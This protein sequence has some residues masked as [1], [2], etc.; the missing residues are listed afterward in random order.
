MRYHEYSIVFVLSSLKFGGTE[1]VAL[2]LA[3]EFKSRGFRVTFLLLSYEGEYLNEAVKFFN[4]FDLRCDRTWKLPLKLISY[5][6]RGKPDIL[7]SSFWKLNVCACI[8]R[9]F[10]QKVRLLLWEHSP[11]SRSKNSSTFLYAISASILYRFATN[12]IAV[13]SGVWNDIDSNTIGLRNKL[14]VI[15]NPIPDPTIFIDNN[16]VLKTKRRIVWVG[17][18]DYSKNPDLMLD[19]FMILSKS[20]GFTL[21]FVGDGPLRINLEKKVLDHDLAEVVRFHG[22]QSNPYPL[23]MQS[24]ILA[25]T[26]DC[27]G[28]PTVLI[29]ALYLGLRVVSTDSGDGIHDI[30]LD[31][32]Y[33][34][35]VQVSNPEAFARALFESL[36]RPFDSTLQLKAARRFSPDVVAEQFLDNLDLSP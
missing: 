22:F 7:I 11:P 12:V 15:F 9:I 28:L 16:R 8:A 5:L 4:V 27:E 31:N 29:E 20:Q 25:L 30:L 33:G 21:D 23:M 3:H 14:K 26:S 10:Y 2:N 24:E 35:I 36:N 19:A 34:T 18:L 32:V 17:R 1:R 13:S 6:R